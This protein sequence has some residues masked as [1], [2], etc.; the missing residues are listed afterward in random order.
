MSLSSAA[1]LVCVDQDNLYHVWDIVQPLLKDA[2]LASREKWTVADALR[3]LQ[4]NE[5]QLW[6]ILW[7]G[8][9]IAAVLT[10]LVDLD[11][12]K[13]CKIVC[14]AGHDIRRWVDHNQT[15]EQWAKEQGCRAM[16]FNAH[17]VI[18][19][20][21]SRRGYDMTHIVLEKEL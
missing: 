14:C 4:N 18:A 2:S 19:K 11:N 10:E 20:L 9:I 6:V 3:R 8:S 15:I 21:L 1:D 7:R 5:A 17:P 16:Y 13:V 12:C